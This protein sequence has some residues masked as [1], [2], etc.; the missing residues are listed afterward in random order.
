[1]PISDGLQY[2]TDF[3]LDELTITSSSGQRV[4]I[5]EILR[6]LVLYEDLFANAM[7][8]KIGRAHV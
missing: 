4:D 8:G 7:T 5:R 2:A 6:E 3:Q 1:M